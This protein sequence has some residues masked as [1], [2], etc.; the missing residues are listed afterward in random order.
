ME[1]LKGT[2]ERIVFEN[3]ETGYV[4]ARLSS[5]DYPG[6]LV[7]V[8]GNLASANPGESLL[9][10]GWWVNN[11]QYGR[12]FKIE[13]YET[14]LPATVM[15]MQKY[16]GSGMIKGIG[17]VMARR[18]VDL[19]GLDTIDTIETNPDKLLDVPGIGPKRV[20]R[21]KRAWEEQRDIKDIMIFLQSHSVTTTY[22]V[23]I[24]KT[25]EKNSIQVVR[26]E[27]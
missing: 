2:L 10:H 13:S 27:P 12:Q 4:I 15:G 6:E 5:R 3:V 26:A 25:Y 17:P 16:L 21:I 8:V 14:I 22:A 18:I 23:K 11:P 24:Y 19:F 9:L 1:T 20:G 7:T